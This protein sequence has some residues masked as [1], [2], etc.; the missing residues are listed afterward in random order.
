MVVV[1]AAARPLAHRS[2]T[3]LGTRAAAV[4]RIPARPIR[5]DS[6]RPA[7]LL[8]ERGPP[9]GADGLLPAPGP[10]LAPGFGFVA[11]SSRGPCDDCRR[12][13]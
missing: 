12:H 4:G 11:G 1:A 3:E 9:Q 6:R 2:R 5:E 7:V 8:R 13:E 10:A